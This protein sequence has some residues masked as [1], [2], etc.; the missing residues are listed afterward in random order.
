MGRFAGDA[1]LTAAMLDRIPHYVSA[2]QQQRRD[3]RG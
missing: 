2:S 1:V 3:R